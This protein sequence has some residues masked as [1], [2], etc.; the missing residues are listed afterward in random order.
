MWRGRERASGRFYDC[1]GGVNHEKDVILSENI[2][3]CVT[4]ISDPKRL[5]H[6]CTHRKAHKERQNTLVLTHDCR[7]TNLL[8]IDVLI[9]YRQEA[10]RQR[11]ANNV[12]TVRFK[13]A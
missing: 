9:V 2:K 7:G 13:K 4:E 6:G 5:Y 11:I 12:Q 8:H 10:R 3:A 1:N